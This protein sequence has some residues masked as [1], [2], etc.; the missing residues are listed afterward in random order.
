MVMPP[1]GTFDYVAIVPEPANTGSCSWE[2]HLRDPVEPRGDHLSSSRLVGL[3]PRLQIVD[4]GLPS[5]TEMA[6]SN[7]PVPP[8]V[9]RSQ[10]TLTASERVNATVSSV[11]FYLDKGLISALRPND[12]LHLVRTPNAGLGVSV[13]R[14]GQLVV[15]V[16]AITAVPLGRNVEERIPL[17]LVQEAEAVFKRHDPDFEFP[18]LPVEVTVGNQRRII[19]GG[20]RQMDQYNVFMIHGQSPVE[21]GADECLA[22]SLMGACSEV[23]A[24]ASAMLLDSGRALRIVKW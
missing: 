17:D 13:I 2:L 12:V 18:V 5:D 3:S 14:D 24:N 10:I 1:S 15:A 4:A 9:L 19:F 8:K 16:G 21:D 23:A 7:W 20:S 6:G 11:S 22:I